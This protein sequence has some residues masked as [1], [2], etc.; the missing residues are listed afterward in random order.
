M[1]IREKVI[2][3]LERKREQF[4]SFRNEQR[5]QVEQVAEKLDAFLAYD[6]AAILQKLALAGL[7]WPGALP[8]AEF[9]LAERLCIP[10][11]QSWNSHDAARAWAQPIL[12]DAP[13]AAVDGSQIM[14]TKDIALPLGAVQIGWFINYHEPGGR[15]E[16]DVSF[17]VLAP[18]ELGDATDDLESGFPD[19]RVNQ[20]RFVGECERICALMERLAAD[21]PPRPPL[22][23]FDGS[24][25]ISFAGQLR[26]SRAESY[27]K[28][29][30]AMLNASRELRVPLAGFVD[31]SQ[32]RDLVTLLNH[33]V[34]PPHLS[35]SDGAL[36]HRLL[37]A[38]GDRTPLFQ[39]ARLDI[40]TQQQ[41]AP[42]YKEIAFCYMR[43]TA[44]R[45]PA[46]IELPLWMVE[47]GCA[48]AAL[49]LVR[50]EC[51]IGAGYPYAIETADATAV[52]QQADRERFLALVQQFADR[53]GLA[54]G[55]TRKLASKLT[56][57][58]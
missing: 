27:L 12:Q 15:Y 1:L 54:F 4:L 31:S 11:G 2:A 47:A 30:Q 3:A 33:V 37:P 26:P 29:V 41:R 25:V 21:P 17:E 49:D 51:V 43:L 50:A 45:P 53:E 13:V 10:F 32:S 44:D 24:L 34:G 14:P 9:D 28:S 42:F 5:H 46:R 18:N 40:L 58:G 35:L 52:I 8:T 55:Q 16:K 38:W 19:W 57:R 39:C 56:R 23:F 6:Q 22:C 36:L 48:D 7:D 20:R